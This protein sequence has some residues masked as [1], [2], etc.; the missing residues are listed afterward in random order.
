MILPPLGPRVEAK[1]FAMIEYWPGIPPTNN[2]WNQSA[3]DAAIKN[4][5]HVGTVCYNAR[6]ASVLEMLRI[7]AASGAAPVPQAVLIFSDVSYHAL[8]PTLDGL[9]VRSG[10]HTRVRVLR[11]TNIP[12]NW[13]P[14][15]CSAGRPSPHRPSIVRE[16]PTAHCTRARARAPACRAQERRDANQGGARAGHFHHKGAPRRRG[17]GS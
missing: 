9:C 16:R 17:A 4:P 7:V 2:H 15:H 5:Q 10:A 13:C 6:V 3:F 1:D 11:D 14:Y 8:K 12:V